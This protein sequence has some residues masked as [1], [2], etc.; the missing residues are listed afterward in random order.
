MRIHLFGKILFMFIFISCV[1]EIQVKEDISGITSVPEL[2]INGRIQSGDKTKVYISQTQPLGSEEFPV[3]IYNAKV[4]VV[5]E[6]GYESSLAEYDRE[7]NCYVIDTKELPANSRYCLKVMLD[8]EVYQSEFM[9][10]L[11]SPMIDSVTYKEHQSEIFNGISLHVSTHGDDS[12]SRFYLWTYEEDWEFHAPIDIIGIGGGILDYS[13]DFYQFDEANIYNHY[14]FC[15]QHLESAN[16]HIYDTSILTSNEVKDVELFRISIDDIRISYIYRILVKQCSLDK[17]AFEYYNLLKKQSEESG[18]LFAPMPTEVKGN[19]TCTSNP[20]IKVHGY[21]LAS[22]VSTKSLFV[23][24]SN[25]SMPSEY[26]GECSI[27][28]PHDL[29]LN[30]EEYWDV[31]IS[32][33]GAIALTTNGSYYPINNSNYKQSKLYQRECVDC[34]TVKGSTKKRPDFWPN[35]HE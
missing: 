20:D 29:T 3:A 1:E 21:V 31:Q 7:N 14:Y 10:V 27:L 11:E 25:L 34:R 13:P 32:K 9:D 30:W 23:Y 22:S 35:N 16:I 26:E 12:E 19:V 33:Y 2:V 15:W 24:E 8:G 5:G 28:R 17:K 6:N 4:Y 18:G